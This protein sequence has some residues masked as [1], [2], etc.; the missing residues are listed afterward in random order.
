[1]GIGA[2]TA[3]TLYRDRDRVFGM[4]MVD[5][6]SAVAAGSSFEITFSYPDKNIARAVV[7]ALVS[8]MEIRHAADDESIENNADPQARAAYGLAIDVLPQTEDESATHYRLQ[9]TAA[10]AAIRLL[11]AVA[12]WS[13]GHNQPVTA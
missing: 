9:V 10:G 7:A 4:H 5:P 6:H 12:R 3:A 2:A 13:G 11:L 8:E 1:M